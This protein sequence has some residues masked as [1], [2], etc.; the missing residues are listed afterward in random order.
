MT[1]REVARLPQLL[2][3]YKVPVLTS[4]VANPTQ[5]PRGEVFA[6]EVLAS[7]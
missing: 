3:A 2:M 1:V 7:S 6:L 5:V 4:A